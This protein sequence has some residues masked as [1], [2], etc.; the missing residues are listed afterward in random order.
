VRQFLALTKHV[1]ASCAHGR[2][3]HRSGVRKTEAIK[4]WL[5]NCRHQMLVE[6]RC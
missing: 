6:D 4:L 5:V 2:P 3:N 1:L